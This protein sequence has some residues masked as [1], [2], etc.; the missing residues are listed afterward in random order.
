MNNVHAKLN[1][2]DPLT[3]SA[4]I[5]TTHQTHEMDGL[6]S[7]G[8]MAR[9]ASN[10]W[11]WLRCF[12]LELRERPCSR[13]RSGRPSDQQMGMLLWLPR[14]IQQARGKRC[15]EDVI[16]EMIDKTQ[17]QRRAGPGENYGEY[18]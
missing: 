6:R 14:E 1:V 18:G 12:E 10:P 15:L 11:R 17:Y 4:T 5:H 9:T 7:S 13:G 2:A 3:K 16:A 8:N